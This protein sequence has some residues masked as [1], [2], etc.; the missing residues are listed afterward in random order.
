MSDSYPVDPGYRHW[1]GCNPGN[2]RLLNILSHW[3][4][5]M[6]AEP[7]IYVLHIQ[8]STNYEVPQV[9]FILCPVLPRYRN[10]TVLSILT[11]HK[12]QN[13]SPQP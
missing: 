1:S 5:G 11:L 9:V 13:S 3:A 12:C 6:K 8:G 4:K 10:C 2:I 7:F